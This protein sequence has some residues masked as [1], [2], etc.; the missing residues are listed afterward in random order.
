MNPKEIYEKNKVYTIL[1]IVYSLNYIA[2]YLA[3]FP[4][5]ALM[6]NYLTHSTDMFIVSMVSAWMMRNIT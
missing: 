2:T 4:Y 3:W 1:I 5:P 6:Q